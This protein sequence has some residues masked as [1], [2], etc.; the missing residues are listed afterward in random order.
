MISE[1]TIGGFLERLAAGK[2]TPGG[3]A[4]AAIQAAQ[5]AALISMAA[6]FTT[7]PRFADHERDA[8]RI[9]R[10][11]S[12]LIP[13]SLALA[14]DDERAFAR[15][16]S[17]YEL[18]KESET[19]R[20]AR[21]GVIQDALRE[22]V[23]PPKKLIQITRSILALGEE[24]AGFANPDVRSDI[25]AALEA[26]RSAAAGARATLAAD[27]ADITDGKIAGTLQGPAA[28]A[29]EIIE[30]CGRLSEQLRTQI[31]EG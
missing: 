19:E 21:S 29:E 7:G 17:A 2:A 10:L 4:A 9:A 25:A 5:A 23:R 13:Q 3:G 11:A 22:A 27:R 1:E 20:G 18:P 16:A 8:R 15:V 30:S 14:D 24:L 12:D 26:A 31:R 28:D 6:N